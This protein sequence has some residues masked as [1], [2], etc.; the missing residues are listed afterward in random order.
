MTG[1]QTC[2]LPILF[3]FK[4]GNI[5]EHNQDTQNIFYGIQNPS[6]IMFTSNIL[7]Q[8]PKV[9]DNFVVESNLMPSFVY[10]YND[11]PYIQTSDLA[12]TD[13]RQLEGIWY[14]NILRNKIVPTATGFTTD[15][16]LTA[17][18]MRNTNM[19]V[20]VDF[21]PDTYPLELRLVQLGMSISKGHTIT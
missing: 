9:Y 5:Y 17:E 16:L 21:Y 18:V 8:I 2:A 12:N 3:S 15:G 10:F 11:F 19:F 7:A 1:V 4:N 6:K 20:E 13:F 14:A